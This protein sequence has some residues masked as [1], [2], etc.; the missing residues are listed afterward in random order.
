[1]LG[2][3]IKLF[4][5][6]CA[7]L[8][9]QSGYGRAED[10]KA[11]LGEITS[12]NINIRSDSTVT[13]PI[14]YTL[15]KGDYINV[16]RELYDWYRIKLPKT[17]PSYI[18]KDLIALISNRAAKVTKNSVNIRL[19]PNEASPIVG[20]A[21]QDEIITILESQ[22]GQWYKI[23]PIDNSFGWV[24]KRFVKKATYTPPPANTTSVM[25]SAGTQVVINKPVADAKTEKYVTLEGI[26]KP[27]GRVFRRIATHKLIDKNDTVYLLKGDKKT[28]NALNNHK[29]RIVGK[30]I[31]SEKESTPLIQIDK[32]EAL[33]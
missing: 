21:Y 11:F 19:S 28:L 26:I 8:A 33:D 30:I 6:I 7:C 25:T 31:P 2:K 24:N 27:Y 4:L 32:I 9:I 29:T 10:F 15:N 12:A 13:A 22:D 16:T 1:M 14:I 5:I 20:K 3:T 18:K 23:E 17:A